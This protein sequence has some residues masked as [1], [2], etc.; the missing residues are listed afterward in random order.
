MK[1]LSFGRNQ[2]YGH[3]HSMSSNWLPQ[4]VFCVLERCA[5]K[6]LYALFGP[7]RS[8]R[9]ACLASTFSFEMME[10]DFLHRYLTLDRTMQEQ[11]SVATLTI[12]T[13][14]DMDV[15]RYKNSLLLFRV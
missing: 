6:R 5:G 14:L 3:I 2:V 8:S 9:S 10:K 13:L 7:P 1:F 12:L 4:G 15:K 11:T